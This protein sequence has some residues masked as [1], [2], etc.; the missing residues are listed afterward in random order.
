[1][2]STP[3]IS[4]R[5]AL[6]SA[7]AFCLAVAAS[8][9]AQAAY[10]QTYTSVDG[11]G[12]HGNPDQL[13][14]NST[15]APLL[16][17]T[18]AVA[19]TTLLNQF[20]SASDST[21]WILGPYATT[22]SNVSFG[23]A[24][25]GEAATVSFTF[26]VT[27]AVDLSLASDHN[28]NGEFGLQLYGQGADIVWGSYVDVNCLG[29]GGHIGNGSLSSHGISTP[30]DGSSVNATYTLTTTVDTGR[31]NAGRIEVHTALNVG[32]THGSFDIRLTSLMLNGQAAALVNNGAAGWSISA[33]PEPASYG[34]ALAGLLVAALARRRQA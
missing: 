15:G 29:C 31:A 2:P 17:T 6:S 28:T 4:A 8:L 18:G 1:M 3:S 9:P 24:G 10:F 32:G 21:H 11:G 19:S 23:V 13:E 5:W 34:L 26:V 12:A 27:G 22:N 20:V 25:A 14:F 16:S 30:W 33:V 7:A